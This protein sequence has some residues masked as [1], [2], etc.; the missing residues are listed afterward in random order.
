M[1][2]RFIAD[3]INHELD[4]RGID[5]ESVMSA[6]TDGENIVLSWWLEEQTVHMR[7]GAAEKFVEWL[8]EAFPGDYEKWDVRRHG[9][10]RPAY[11]MLMARQIAE[12]VALHA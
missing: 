4:R 5:C 9:Q 11:F 2:T 8:W 1:T 3:V 12:G 7:H 10:A 6:D